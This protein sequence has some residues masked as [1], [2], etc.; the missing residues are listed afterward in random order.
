MPHQYWFK[1]KEVTN[2][3]EHI[4]DHAGLSAL[5]RTAWSVLSPYVSLASH[6]T[7][8]QRRV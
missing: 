5:L 7:V 4:Q 1:A 2:R 8:A 6:T 3:H